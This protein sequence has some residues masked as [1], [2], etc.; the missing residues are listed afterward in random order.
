MPRARTFAHMMEMERRRV[1]GIDDVLEDAAFE[2]AQALARAVAR[3]APVDRG[4][5]KAGIEVT[6][7]RGFPAVEANAPHSGVLEEGARPFNPPHE[8][9]YEWVLRKFPDVSE[10]E[11][12]GVAFAVQ[13][14]IGQRGLPA[15]YIMRRN[16]PLARKV[17]QQATE[18]RLTLMA[19]R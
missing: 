18:R 19:A 4:E 13:R 5:Y 8:P 2:S 14:A 7:H 3:D 6:T 1:R 11:A 16:L 15:L 17:L 12:H 10:E 9:L